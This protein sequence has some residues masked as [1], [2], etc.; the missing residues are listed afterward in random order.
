MKETFYGKETFSKIDYSDKEL[1]GKEFNACTFAHCNFLNSNLSHN[2]FTNCYFDTCNLSMAMLE[3]TKLDNAQFINCKIMGVDF[4]KCSD[5]LFSASFSK[6]T[7]DFTQ[8]LGKNLKKIKFEDCSMKEAN[9][10]ESNLTDAALINCDL[11][12]TVF[13]RTT[14]I[15]A[16]FRT[17]YNYTI[18]PELNRIKNAKF[19]MNGVLGLLEKYD[20]SVE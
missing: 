18:D 12:R 17:S 7:L 3:H 2:E 13:Y 10:T 15:K 8:F 20:I 19:S 11:S 14:L 1:S 6:C 16:D 5:F 4:S 9:F